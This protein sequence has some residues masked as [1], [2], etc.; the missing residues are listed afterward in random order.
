MPV[1]FGK[2][3]TP[4]EE[5]QEEARDP[6]RGE[7]WSGILKFFTSPLLRFG[8]LSQTVVIVIGFIIYNLKND[9]L[10]VFTFDLFSTPEALRNNPEYTGSMIFLESL[11]LLGSMSLAGFQIFLSDN[12]K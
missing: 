4:V 5:E 9:R 3:F 1:E 2:Y 11:F 6:D 12:S 7:S 8:F 10:G